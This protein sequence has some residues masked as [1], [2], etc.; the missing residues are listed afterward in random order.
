MKAVELIRELDAKKI[1][2]VPFELTI[3]F[4]QLCDVLGIAVCGGAFASDMS[5]QWVYV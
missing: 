2:F 3:Q 5:G 1:T 4:C